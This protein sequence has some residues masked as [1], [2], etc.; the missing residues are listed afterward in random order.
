MHWKHWP[1]WLK[2]GV[3]AAVGSMAVSLSA[4]FCE[5]FIDLS[6]SG[7]LPIVC[8]PLE[9]VW[10]PTLA[11]PSSGTLPVYFVFPTLAWFIIGSLIGT[12]IGLVKKKKSLP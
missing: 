9:V 12:T 10:L 2:G 7:G 1:Y 6:N 3:I 5:R 11:F 4:L 8:L